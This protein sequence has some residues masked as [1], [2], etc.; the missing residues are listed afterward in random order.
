MGLTLGPRRFTPPALRIE[1]LPKPDIVLLSHAH[2]DHMDRATLSALCERWPNQLQLIT[3]TNTLDVVEDLAWHTKQ[4][5]DWNETGTVCGVT[6]T[7]LQVAHNGWR[8]P[9]E[10]CRAAGQKRTGRSFNGYLLERNGV[11]VVFGGDTAYTQTFAN[12]KKGVDLAI[13]PIGAYHGYQDMHC[14]PE[15]AV[16]MCQMMGARSIMPVHFG[17]FRQSEEPPAEPP[18]RLMKAIQRTNVLVVGMGLGG[19]FSIT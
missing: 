19:S 13:M 9:G 4:E 16:A 15:E 7:A 5:M 17:T 10:P 3:A 2:L 6:I 18:H 12:L 1:E 14:T 8:I 11:Q